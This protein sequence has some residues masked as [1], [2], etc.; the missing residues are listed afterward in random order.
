LP[1]PTKAT[2]NGANSSTWT[3]D[4]KSVNGFNEP[5]QYGGLDRE[6][7]EWLRNKGLT[8]K[9]I[10]YS[11]IFMHLDH[12]RGYEQPDISQKNYAI[13]Q[14]TVQSKRS[15]TDQGIVKTSLVGPIGPTLLSR[16]AFLLPRFGIKCLV[17][18]TVAAL[19]WAAPSLGATYGDFSRCLG[20]W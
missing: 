6:L 18:M 16:G 12:Q 2:W 20:C 8:F 19:C 7:G 5:M 17:P 10:R 3:A 4:L 14:E 9:Q 13:R 1:K 15:W 11:T